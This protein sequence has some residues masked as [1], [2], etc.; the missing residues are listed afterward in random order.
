MSI[1]FFIPAALAQ[2]KIS[3]SIPGSNQITT[4]TSPG[5]LISNFYQFALLIGGILAFG[6][7]VY[8]GVKYMSS[9]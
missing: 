6:A 2:T 4:G 9:A 8:G 1:N 5:A 3:L 7:I